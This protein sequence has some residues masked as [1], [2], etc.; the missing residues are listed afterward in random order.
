MYPQPPK[1]I[2]D[3]KDPLQWLKAKYQLDT[4]DHVDITCFSDGESIGVDAVRA[5]NHKVALRPTQLTHKLFIFTHAHLITEAAQNAL[6]KLLETDC[7]YI[8]WYFFVDVQNETSLLQTLRSRLVKEYGADVNQLDESLCARFESILNGQALVDDAIDFDQWL[9]FLKNKMNECKDQR[10]I[11][12]IIERTLAVRRH[13]AQHI[14]WSVLA[15]MQMIL[16]ST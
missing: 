1:L 10:R 7:T 12:G 11:L 8:H 3:Q 4:L 9:L 14:K 6:L 2:V 15:Q 13:Q 16:N 5:L